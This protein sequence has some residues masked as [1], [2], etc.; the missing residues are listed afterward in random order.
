M[1]RQA[2]TL[3]AAALTLL[4]IFSPLQAA[5]LKFVPCNDEIAARELS[6]R[7]SKGPTTLKELSALRR[8]KSYTVATG[9]TPLQLIATDRDGAAVTIVLPADIKS[10]LV[11]ILAD[12]ENPSGLRTLVVEDSAA[13]FPWGSLHFINLTQGPLTV[14]YEK[15]TLALP[16]GDAPVQILPEGDARNAGVQI[17]KEDA[18]DAILYSAVWEHD[19]NLRKLVLVVPDTNPELKTFELKIIPEDRRTAK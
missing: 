17:F 5:T 3:F 12:S 18:P 14:R 11:L 9:K 16:E 8:S 4:G 1:T 13:G 15:Q 7:D 19:P 6:V 10:P 2:P